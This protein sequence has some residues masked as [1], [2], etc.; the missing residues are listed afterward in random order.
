[1]RR[2]ALTFVV[3][4]MAENL[5]VQLFAMMFIILLNFWYLA[6]YSP[7]K[8]P[9]MQRL[10]MFNELTTLA[11]LYNLMCFSAANNGSVD[12]ESTFDLSFLCFFCGNLCVHLYFLLRNTYMA[13]KLKCKKAKRCLTRQERLR[14]E[15][16]LIKTKN[17]KMMMI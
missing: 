5:F 17:T 11:L 16:E 14:A 4:I 15:I 7:F 10:E 13:T 9:L 1:M 3:I 2:I 12:S 8:E 6:S